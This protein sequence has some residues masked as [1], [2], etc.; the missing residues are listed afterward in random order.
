M[1]P[2]AEPAPRPK[3]RR[4]NIALA[5]FAFLAASAITAWNFSWWSPP[6]YTPSATIAPKGTPLT[7]TGHDARV[8]LLD[9]SPYILHIEPAA[10]EQKRGALLFFGSRHSKDPDAPQQAALQRAWAGFRPTVA[11]VEGRMSFFVGTARQGIQV[12]GEGAAVYSLAEQANLPLFTLEPPLE[13]EIAALDEIGDR[14]QVALFRFL[15]GYMS[16]KRGGQVSDFKINR[17]LSK[18]AAPLTDALPDIPTLD[19]YFAAQ[20]PQ[21]KGWRDLPEQA[22]WPGRTDTW[23]NKMA[24]RSNQARD[25]HFT[26]TMLDLVAK[27]ER[28]LAIA[29]RSH[30]INLEPVLWA[31]LQPAT[32]GNLS[33]PRPWES[34]VD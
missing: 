21:F 16:A 11:L 27:G 12:F 31:S 7:P 28:V 15:S 20:F 2:K 10:A 1:P 9:D 29:G 22:L 13:V 14:K 33:S 34:P 26:R 18:R 19:S 8:S 25:D 23:L 4:R 5:V 24:T 32:R 6:E 17:L 3:N 30:T